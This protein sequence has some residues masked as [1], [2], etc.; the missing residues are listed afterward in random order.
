MTESL[1]SPIYLLKS[2]SITWKKQT[3]CN[4]MTKILLSKHFTMPVHSSPGKIYYSPIVQLDNLGHRII[5]E[6]LVRSEQVRRV[7]GNSTAL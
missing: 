4:T 7:T 2:Y 3:H 1:I 5:K 6:L